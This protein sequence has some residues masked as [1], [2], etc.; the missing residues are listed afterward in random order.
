MLAI[1]TSH[2]IQTQVPLWRALAADGRVPF[3]VWFPTTHGV[4]PSHDGE[5]GRTFAWDQDLLSGYPHRFLPIAPGWRLDRFNGIQVTENW[6]RLWDASGVSTVWVEGWRFAAVWAAVKSARATGRRVWLR[7]ESPDAPEAW[8]DRI[9]KR[10][11]LRWL[12][13]QV[14]QFLVIGTSNRRFYERYGIARHHLLP[15][16]YSVDND[17]WN[18]AVS[19]LAGER[20]AIRA[21]WGIA[22]EAICVLVAGKLIPK[23]RPLDAWE[24]VRVVHRA[25]RPYHLLYVGDGALRPA[26]ERAVRQA[27]GPPATLAGFLNLSEMPRAY[28]AADV[29]VLPSDRGETW[30]LVVNEALAAGVPAIVSDRCGCAPDLIAPIDAALVFRVTEPPDLARALRH[31]RAHPPTPTALA[32]RLRIHSSYTTVNT[33]AMHW[34]HSAA[35]ARP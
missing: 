20:A 22:P 25:D 31:L 29:L 35:P 23:K 11:L 15:A 7:G 19:A 2:P 10:P 4:Q 26:V 27:G 1:I 13:R 21:A 24:A 3:E 9:W 17:Y 16:P 18:R 6:P 8:H 14:D 33:V 30:G 28:A 5:F 12:F 32:A 34:S